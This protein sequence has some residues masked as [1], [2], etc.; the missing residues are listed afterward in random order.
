MDNEADWQCESCEQR[1][2]ADSVR[3]IL[4]ES[5]HYTNS[6]D[7]STTG[8]IDHYENIIFNLSGKLHPGNFLLLEV[9][10]KLALLYGNIYPN[11]INR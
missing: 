4:T 8:V 5:Q 11:T 2:L 7:M 10:Q 1:L 6:P 9:K 3:Q